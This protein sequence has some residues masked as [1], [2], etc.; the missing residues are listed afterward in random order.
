[1]ILQECNDFLRYEFR[2]DKNIHR[3]F[4]YN[5]YTIGIECTCACACACA[6]VCTCTLA[7]LS[8][9]CVTASLHCYVVKFICRHLV[10][11]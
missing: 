6:C 8:R 9:C 3:Q 7:I 5:Y 10:I 4:E 11:F 2:A 1:M